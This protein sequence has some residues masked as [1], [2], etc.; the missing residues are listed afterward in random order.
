MLGEKWEKLDVSIEIVG[1]ESF[2]MLM[3]GEWVLAEGYRIDVFDTD[4]DDLKLPYYLTMIPSDKSVLIARFVIV[5]G[6]T[7]TIVFKS[8]L[9][10]ADVLKQAKED[11]FVFEAFEHIFERADNSIEILRKTEQEIFEWMLPKY[12][13][14][15]QI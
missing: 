15:P 5:S 8:P 4:E 11:V 7:G 12:G 10:A 13:P 14:K 6:I 1:L 3:R 9:Y 2:Y